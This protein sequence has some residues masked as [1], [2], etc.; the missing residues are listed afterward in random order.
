VASNAPSRAL[1]IVPTYNEVENLASLV[2]A[3]FAQPADL[4]LLVVDDNSPDGTGKLA[5]ELA[6]ANPGRLSVLHRSDKNGIGP[7]YVAGFKLALQSDVE[8]IVTMDADLSHDPHDLPRMLLAAES[9]DV[10]IG[11][12]YVEGG[13]TVGWPFHRR[14][15]SKGGGTYARYVLGVPVHDLTSGYKVYRREV[16]EQFDFGHIRSDGYGFQI[17]TVY[18][19]I[20][21]GFRVVEIPIEFHDRTRGKSKLSRRI[22]IEAAPM[23]WK[24]R[25][26]QFQQG[27]LK[28]K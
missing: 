27:R 19:A 15:I 4:S 2:E 13:S 28:R 14:L 21:S 18:R 23:V 16:I 10:V 7:A 11:S 24:L 1:V 5:D 3:V 9:A 12:R 22:V 6:M 20:R 25:F 26:E 17:E 8:L